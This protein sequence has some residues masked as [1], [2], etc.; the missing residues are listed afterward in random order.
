MTTGVP[1]MVVVLPER[2]MA[3]LLGAAVEPKELGV[4]CPGTGENTPAADTDSGALA[5]TDGWICEG[6]FSGEGEPP[7]AGAFRDSGTPEA[8]TAELA[9]WF[10]FVVVPVAW[11]IMTGPTP[12]V[13]VAGTLGVTGGVF[14]FPLPV[15]VIIVEL[16]RPGALI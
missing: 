10:W 11:E 7:L 4:T 6:L 16:V 3:G 12:D 14:K 13:A 2:E 8:G 5:L 15:T 9:G 1:E